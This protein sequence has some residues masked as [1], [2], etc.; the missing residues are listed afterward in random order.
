VVV[1]SIALDG[2]FLEETELVVEDEI[3]VGSIVEL[4]RQ[5]QGQLSTVG[6]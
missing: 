5:R 3:M 4:E 6:V 1:D 2:V